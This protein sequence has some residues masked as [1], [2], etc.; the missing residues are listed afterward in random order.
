MKLMKMY[1]KCSRIIKCKLRAIN[2]FSLRKRKENI[3]L[4]FRE[5]LNMNKRNW[6]LNREKYNERKNW[7]RKKRIKLD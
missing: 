4:S 3:C 5:S 6:N 2:R 1:K 7:L